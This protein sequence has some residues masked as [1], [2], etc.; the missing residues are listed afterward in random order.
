MVDKKGFIQPCR[1]WGE[2]GS[3]RGSPP[4]AYTNNRLSNIKQSALKSYIK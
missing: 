3:G 4:Q 2:A 1:Q